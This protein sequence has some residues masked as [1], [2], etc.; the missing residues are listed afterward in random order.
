VNR[1]A[2]ERLA[3]WRREWSVAT[4]LDSAEL[5][6]LT[7]HLLDAAERYRAE[8]ASAEDAIARAIDRLG[9]PAAVSAEYTK[10]R[11]RATRWDRALSLLFDLRF[12][13]RQIRA[14]PLFSAVAVGSVA[15]AIAANALAFSVVNGLL[16]K[17]PGYGDSHRLV[18]VYTAS[19]DDPR[20]QSVASWPIAD[21]L[22]AFTDLFE[23]VVGYEPLLGRIVLEGNHVPVFGE[24]VD[25]DFFEV[26]GVAP[27]IGRG[28][29]PEDE[30][31]RAGVALLSHDVWQER[32]AGR[33][34]VLGA[35][36]EINGE[37]LTVVGVA[38][39]G[40][41]GA[42]P[43]LASSAWVP[44][45]VLP[46]GSTGQR[47]GRAAPEADRDRWLTQLKARLA[48]GVT[49]PDAEAALKQRA[50]ELAAAYPESYSQ[51]KFRVIPTDDVALS[52][53]L[54]GVAFSLAGGVMAVVAVVLVIASMN[55][56]GFLLA[57]GADRHEEI[58]LRHALGA[59][60]ARIVGQL[61]AESLVV[62]LLGGVLGL[63]LCYWTL[64]LLLSIELPVPIPL[65]FD[66]SIDAAVLLFT[67]GMSVAA[68][69]LFGL[70]PG[71]QATRLQRGRGAAASNAGR[72]AGSG[73][74]RTV[75]LAAQVAVSTVFLVLAGL[76]TRSLWAEAGTDPG[77]RTTRAAVLTLELGSAGYGRDALPDFVS[78]LRE[79]SRGFPQ[80][81]SVAFTTRVPMGSVTSR[82]EVVFA[83]GSGEGAEGLSIESFEIGPGYFDAM[84]IPLLSGRGV[85]DSDRAET[86]PVVVVSRS[87][88]DQYAHRGAEVGALID[89][90]GAAHE[91]VG[92][93]EDVYVN[94]PRE[95]V[96][97]HLYSPVVQRGAFLLSVVG[98]ASATSGEALRALQDLLDAVDP[99]VAV[100][101][102]ATIEDHVALK[103]M[104]PRVA[105]ALLLGA[106]T[107]A[108]LLTVVGVFGA[109]SYGARRRKRELA[110]RLSLGASPQSVTRLVIVSMVRAIAVGGTAGLLVSLAGTGV[111]RGLLYGV[112][113]FDFGTYVIA[114]V[115]LG[116]AAALA[117]WLPARSAGREDLAT[118][119]R[120]N[121]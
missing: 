82:R 96:V 17:D 85:L 44:R 100:W 43:A 5:E 28:F 108:L 110:I 119:L 46:L 45:W 20:Q 40:F 13:V 98:V 99:T 68:A 37:P 67:V 25:R 3:E 41:Q 97:A 15:V 4:E 50:T 30:R 64:E 73:R 19:I 77:F 114:V 121:G 86:R 49:A 93:V 89:L 61:F 60:R 8:G 35:A 91:I 33:P 111:L 84:G 75:L 59:T 118:L 66:F 16:L 55:L 38:P 62:A 115:V 56:A 116:T 53:A 117:A 88:I 83:D 2:Q 34:D 23:G 79:Q 107:T 109:V 24:V 27:F 78:R 106:G 120:D 105:A 63:G 104:G 87:F 36:I 72:V 47:D 94:R 14:H 22:S 29:T 12:A 112:G 21:D 65:D 9:A 32:Y 69:A 90:D 7:S 113:P 71:W 39:E 10:S 80:L 103:L 95:G 92:V 26:L 48:P 31:A 81:E 101:S 11:P 52:P 74:L 57:R 51:V 58:Q 6:E 54:D 102:A 70:I 76:F 42:I 1:A 18:E